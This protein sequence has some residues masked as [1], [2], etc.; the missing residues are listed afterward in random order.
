MNAHDLLD[1]PRG[2]KTGFLVNCFMKVV[3][4]LEQAKIFSYNWDFAGIPV[5]FD[6]NED[7]EPIRHYYL[8]DD[9]VVKAATDKIVAQGKI[10]PKDKPQ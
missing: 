2:N 3:C 4:H 8:A 1:C 5:V 7:L 6:L 10:H 9:A